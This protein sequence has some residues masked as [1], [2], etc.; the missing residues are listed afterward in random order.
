MHDTFSCIEESVGGNEVSSG[1][2]PHAHSTVVDGMQVSGGESLVDLTSLL[3]G[4]TWSCD[5]GTAMEEHVTEGGGSEIL[6]SV[7]W[8]DELV[9]MLS[10]VEDCVACWHGL[11]LFDVGSAESC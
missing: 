9:V 11:V 2:V 3:R 4:S 5:V 7:G 6:E 8:E 1:S 10:E